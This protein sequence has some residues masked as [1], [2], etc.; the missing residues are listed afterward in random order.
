MLDPE[1]AVLIE[2]G[3]AFLGRDKL[4]AA[5]SRGRLDEFHDSLLGRTVV[6]RSQRVG[7]LRGDRY[8]NDHAGEC[9][10]REVWC[11]SGFHCCVLS[12]V[13]WFFKLNLS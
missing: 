10:C 3:D 1:R 2:G 11:A 7:G 12:N 9:N 13:D 5:L 8:E 6:P 4:R